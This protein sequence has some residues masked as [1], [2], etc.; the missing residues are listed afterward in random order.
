MVIGCMEDDLDKLAAWYWLGLE[1]ARASMPALRAYLAQRSPGISLP[2][3][4]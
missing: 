3:Q 1:D 4:P 2:E